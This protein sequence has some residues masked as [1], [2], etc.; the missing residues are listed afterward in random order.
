MIARIQVRRDTSSNWSQNDPYLTLGEIGYETDTHKLKVG[1]INSNEQRLYKWSELPY[2]MGQWLSDSNGNISYGTQPNESIS[3]EI[4]FYPN[5][6]DE[7]IRMVN[8][9]IYNNCNGDWYTAQDAC[10]LQSS[11]AAK[12]ILFFMSSGNI[13]SGEFAVYGVKK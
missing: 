6:N 9:N 1:T 3:C 12:G 7:L 2:Q 8:N 5:N 10:I 4:D 11:T 13:A